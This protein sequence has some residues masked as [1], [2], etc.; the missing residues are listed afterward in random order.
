MAG[1]AGTALDL[2]NQLAM[3]DQAKNWDKELIEITYTISASIAGIAYGPLL[4]NPV[5]QAFGRTAI[6]FWCLVFA[7]AC[8]IWSAC[9]TS[10]GDYERF[11]ASRLF[12]GIFGSIPSI[13]GVGAVYDMFFLHERGKAYAIFHVSFLFG[14]V[15]GPTFGGF[16]VQHT[17]WPWVFWWIVITQG[18]V[19]ILGKC[20]A[21]KVICSLALVLFY[22]SI[23]FLGRDQLPS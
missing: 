6:I 12:D 3:K 1:F 14:T 22:F 13:V 2:A 18:L 5:A 7:M 11:V 9:M 4:I 15:A 8:A 23:L 16:I 10:K 17:N 20:R 21:R 19:L